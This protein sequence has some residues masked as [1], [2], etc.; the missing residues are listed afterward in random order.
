MA[1]KNTLRRLVLLTLICLVAPIKAEELFAVGTRFSQ[2]FE[3]K[4]NGEYIGLG[5][6]IL[7]RFAQQQ[8]VTI[9]Y[10]IAPWRRAQSMV[11]RGQAD[12][13]IGPYFSEERQKHLAFSA[14]PFYRD[15]IVFYARVNHPTP[16]DGSYASIHGLRIGKMQGWSYG[17]LFNERTKTLTINEFADL[18]S[19]IER[20]SRGDLD[21]LATNIRN[22]QAV[23]AQIKI[24]Q[25]I[26]PIMPRI[27]IQDGFMAFPKDVKFQ[28]LQQ[29]FD[30]F[31][32]HMVET[33]EL[34]TLAKIRGVTIPTSMLTD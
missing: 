12:I 34:A 16:W 31:M 21:L 19:G 2:I 13:L 32:Q 3:Q 23:L 11:E 1:L 24:P 17:Y 7:N 27:D 29:R 20:L 26:T 5:V 22:T 18:K 15:E 30:L 6:D 14:Q 4:P 10:Q 9:H 33:G 25:A 8:K 28:P